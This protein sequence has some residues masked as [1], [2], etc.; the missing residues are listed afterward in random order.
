ML[1]FTGQGYRKRLNSNHE[2]VDFGLYREML[3]FKVGGYLPK[4]VKN[5]LECDLWLTTEM[6]GFTKIVDFIEEIFSTCYFLV[7]FSAAL[8]TIRS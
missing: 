3:C 1:L 5:G 7:T 4:I 8:F 6:A 2:Y